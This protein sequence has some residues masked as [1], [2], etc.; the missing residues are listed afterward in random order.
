VTLLWTWQCT[1][2]FHKG[3]IISRVIITLNNYSEIYLQK[4]KNRKEIS[5]NMQMRFKGAGFLYMQV[6]WYIWDR[7]R[8]CPFNVFL[9]QT[10]WFNFRWSVWDLWGINDRNRIPLH[11]I[12]VGDGNIYYTRDWPCHCSFTGFLLETTCFIS[13][14]AVWDLWWTNDKITGFHYTQF[15]LKRVI[16]V[17]H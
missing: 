11:T 7:L 15:L 1:F 17:T 2:R 16:A 3:K 4:N 8:R 6:S 14:R 9:L 5:H 10:T 13:K 12:S